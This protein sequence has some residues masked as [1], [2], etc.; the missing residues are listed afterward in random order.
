MKVR[1][2]ETVQ[3]E[4][5]ISDMEAISIMLKVLYAAVKPPHALEDLRVTG[6]GELEWVRVERYGAHS[7]I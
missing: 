5:E 2:T 1:A 3:K 4:V 6:D 7:S